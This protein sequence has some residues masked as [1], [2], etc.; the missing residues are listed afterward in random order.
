M[1]LNLKAFALT[2]G[3]TLG[4][5]IFLFTWWVIALRGITGELT[6]FGMLYPGYSICPSGSFIG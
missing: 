2:S 3:L 4:V 1:K 5:G 6:I